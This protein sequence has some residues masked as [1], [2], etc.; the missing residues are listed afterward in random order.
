[1]RNK[2]I[3]REKAQSL[4]QTSGVYMMRDLA[5]NVIYIGKAKNLKKRVSSYFMPSKQSDLL[6]NYPKIAAMV[7]LVES[8]DVIEVKSEAEA[9]ILESK[10]I[11]Q[12]KPKYNTLERDDKKFLLLKID[13]HTAIPQFRLTR[14]RTDKQ[15]RYYGP[16]VNSAMLKKTLD[17]LR[18]KYGIL[19]G[20]ARPKQIGQEKYQLYDDARSQIYGKH[21]NI[22]T[23]T[24]YHERVTKACAFLEGKVRGLVKEIEG[25]MLSASKRREYEKAARLRDV[26]FALKQTL[27]P[28]HKFIKVIVPAQVGPKNSLKELRILLGLDQLPVHIECFDISHISG[29]FVVASMVRFTDGTADK[30]QYRRYKIK[31]FIGNDDYRAMEEV[32]GRRYKRLNE[33]GRPFPDLILIDGGKGQISAALKA[34]KHYKLNAPPVVGLAKKKETII[35]ADS[36]PPLNLPLSSPAIH[37]LQRIRDEA[38]RFANTFNADLRSKKLKNSLL[39]E[40]KGIGDKRKQ[41]LIKYFG[42]IENLKKASIE[43]IEEVEGIGPKLAEGLWNFI[44]GGK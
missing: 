1:M 4:P 19:L 6:V 28:K 18:V 30:R 24:E 35:F 23:K 36:R 3:L 7:E 8:I 43:E 22:V 25:K 10:L 26:L 27:E 44:H 17:E 38:H 12:W 33:E 13:L 39:D 32:V 41:L 14:N 37:L 9:L 34:F 2:D 21:P 31:T 15:S 29:T 11:K 16:F 5:G 40:F 20:D 42:G